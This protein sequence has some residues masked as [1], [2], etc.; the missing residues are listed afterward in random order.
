MIR[1]GKTKTFETQRN[2]GSGGDR[3]DQESEEQMSEKKVRWSP[4]EQLA[5]KIKKKQT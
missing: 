2:R 1:I 3:K 5:S 4:N